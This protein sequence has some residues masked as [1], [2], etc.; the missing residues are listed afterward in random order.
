MPD[1]APPIAEPPGRKHRKIL[2]DS[3]E[4]IRKQGFHADSGGVFRRIRGPWRQLARLPGHGKVHLF[5]V[6]P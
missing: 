4:L 3:S 6:N 2:R 1:T 5:Q